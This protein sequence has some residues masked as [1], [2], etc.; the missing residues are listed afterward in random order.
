M[1]WILGV[2]LAAAPALADD[3]A[4][5]GDLMKALELP[6]LAQSLRD[7]G[8][9]DDD[10]KAAIKGARDKEMH[11]DEVA[12]TFEAADAA[13]DEN[14]PV[15]NFGAFVQS[16]LDEGLRGKELADAIKAEHQAHGKGKGHG[17]GGEHGEHGEG[18]HGEGG[19]GEGGEHGKSGEHGA[20]KKGGDKMTRGGG[21][22]GEERSAGTRGGGGDAKGERS[23][24]ERGGPAGTRGD[25]PGKKSD[26]M[27]RGKK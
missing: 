10:V 21:D 15:D 18:A 11:A 24:G 12:E 20:G 17:K 13:V 16:K 5:Q 6:R 7:K 9:A 25:G 19:H 26:G 3:P 22:E 23:A 1:T 27:T 8:V 14:G 2:L 4:P